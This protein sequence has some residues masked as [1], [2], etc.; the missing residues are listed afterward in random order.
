M[1][2]PNWFDGI[3]RGLLR[4]EKTEPAPMAVALRW[5]RLNLQSVVRHVPGGAVFVHCHECRWPVNPGRTHM[6]VGAGFYSDGSNALPA[7]GEQMARI[8]QGARRY[9]GIPPAPPDAAILT[10]APQLHGLV[11]LTE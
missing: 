7:T 4:R 11:S 5:G 10:T 6:A 2:N 1:T 3:W 8:C 9:M